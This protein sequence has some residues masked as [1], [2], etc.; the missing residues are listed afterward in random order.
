M[1]EQRSEAPTLIRTYVHGTNKQ[2]L[3][4]TPSLPPEEWLIHIRNIPTCA[5]KEKKWNRIFV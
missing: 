1:L 5:H 4:R 2:I 3:S